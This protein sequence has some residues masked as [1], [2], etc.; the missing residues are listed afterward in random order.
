MALSKKKGKKGQEKIEVPMASMID[1]VFL[2]LIYFIVTHKEELSEA[3]LAV[4]LPSGGSSQQS[5]DARLL[6]IAVRPGVIALRGKVMNEEQ[7]R[8]TLTRFGKTD[9]DQTVLIKVDSKARTGQLVTVL[10]ICK[11]AKLTELNV[12]SL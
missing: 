6:E 2:L 4:N 8:E 3:H 11:A 9:P 7:L 1:V 10:D 12:V 5:P